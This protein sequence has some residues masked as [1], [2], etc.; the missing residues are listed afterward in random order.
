MTNPIPEYIRQHVKE[1]L[2]WAGFRVAVVQTTP[3]LASKILAKNTKNRPISRASVSKYI[4]EMENGNWLFTGDPIR[5]HLNGRL[6]DGQHRL[7]AISEAGITFPILMV[8]GLEDEEQFAMDQGR[9]RSAGDQLGIAGYDHGAL[10]ASTIKWVILYDNDALFVENMR[11]LAMTTV[12]EIHRYAQ[13]HPGVGEL[14]GLISKE[15]YKSYLPPSLVCAAAV[16]F[17]RI[18]PEEAL[19]F[20]SKLG[21]GA[22][23][24]EDSGI[25]ALRNRAINNRANKR[26]ENDRDMLG[27]LIRVWNA[28]RR[29]RSISKLQLPHGGTFTRESFPKPI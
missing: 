2:S 23:I 22:G 6:L 13:E 17:A 25:L 16:I 1:E 21:S 29:G 5:I 4:A 26:R 11:Q 28:E 19:D 7:T 14:V 3:E 24:R 15:A 9:K 27:L 18:N 10:L 8:F 12:P 20:V